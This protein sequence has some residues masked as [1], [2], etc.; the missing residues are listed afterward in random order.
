[1][2][3]KED[4]D[5]YIVVE[6]LGAFMMLLLLIVSI[7]SLVNIVTLQARVHYAMTQAAHSISM[8][9][10][11]FHV[12]GVDTV[13]SNANTRGDETRV[14]I[15]EFQSELDALISGLG[16]LDTSAIESAGNALYNRGESVVNDPSAMVSA[17]LT[18]GID[19]TVDA[20]A[21][22]IIRPLV[23]YYLAN[24]TQSGDEYLK[25]VQVIGGLEGLNFA[26]TNM[27]STNFIDSDGVLQIT[28][29]YDVNYSFGALPLPFDPKLTIT[30][31][32]KTKL[33][34]GGSGDGYKG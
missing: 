11:V 19:S 34:L 8:Y 33:W 10:Y 30:Q 7:L 3:K 32:V 13:L 12:T 21:R 1:M 31:G 27:S 17:M 9:S 23:G 15:S 18:L 6:T 14:E 4:N 24:S 5:G 26:P 22:S 25:S 2:I 20:A 16:T 29:Q 28:V